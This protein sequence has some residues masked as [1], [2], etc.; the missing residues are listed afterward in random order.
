MLKVNGYTDFF[1]DFL[2]E[3]YY[4][5]AKGAHGALLLWEFEDGLLTPVLPQKEYRKLTDEQ[6][7][8]I[9]VLMQ[10]VSSFAHVKFSFDEQMH[11]ELKLK[12][13]DDVDIEFLLE[14]HQRRAIQYAGGWKDFLSKYTGHF[15]VLIIAVLLLI[16]LIMWF[17][18]MPDFA[19]QCYGAAQNAVQQSYLQA[20]AEAL[21]PAG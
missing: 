16:G 3:N 9:E 7:A 15:V 10:Q 18:N 20:Q 8:E 1:R 19:A 21:R 13:I 4:P 5:T 14:Q 17:Q 6:K 2:S 11:H 12:A